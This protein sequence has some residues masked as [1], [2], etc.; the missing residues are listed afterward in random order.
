MCQ[1]RGPH[2]KSVCILY[3][4]TCANVEGLM[5]SVCILYTSTCANVEGLMGR[6]FVYYILVRVPMQRASWEECLYIIY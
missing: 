2:G 1:C 4:S 3:T 6:V 5:G